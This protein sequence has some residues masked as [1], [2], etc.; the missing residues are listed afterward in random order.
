MD[1]LNVYSELAECYDRL[2]QFSMRDRF[3]ILA[4]DA[5]LETGQPGEAERMRLRLLQGSRHHMLRPY[6]SFA[7][8]ARAPDVQTYLKDLRTNYPPS[9]AELLLDS[10]KGG[11]GE[12][13]P[14]T[15]FDPTQSLPEPEG[16]A[17]P[18]NDPPARPIPPT[19]PL[20]DISSRQRSAPI[21]GCSPGEPGDPDIYPIREEHNPRPMAQPI[22]S[23]VPAAR[24]PAGRPE[25]RPTRPTSAIPMTLPAV[26]RVNAAAA[27]LPRHRE[28]PRPLAS[29]RQGA[30][31]PDQERETPPE[32]G[33]WFVLLL[34][35][36]VCTAGLALLAF[37]FA[38][39]FL[40]AGWLP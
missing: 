35:G 15:A 24:P 2:G 33:A 22:P 18:T 3:L 12:G 37:T 13:P 16:W 21:A 25:E 36:V 17:T 28:A 38:R 8:A 7:E 11:S 31:S 1:R 5:A 4:A 30:H 40:P 39:P 20:I 34:L 26:P 6:H 29:L 23:R 14:G 10:L 9:V 32:G 27:P 19:A